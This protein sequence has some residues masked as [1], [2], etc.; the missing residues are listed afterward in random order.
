MSTKVCDNTSVAALIFDEDGRLLV[1]D[2]NTD[3][4]GA[5]GPAGHIDTHGTAADAVCAEVH[6]EVGLNVVRLELFLD[7]WWPNRCRRQPGPR[8]IG[9]HFYFYKVQVTG[10]LRPSSRETRNVR[11]L[12]RGQLRE[13]TRRTIKYARGFIS[14]VEFRAAPGIEPVWVYGLAAAGLVEASHDDLALLDQ[15]AADFVPGGS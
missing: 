7:A 2:R 6:E 4:P 11:W 10:H 1:F 14:H 12:D 13:L 3:P 15:V 9:H 8:G 5:A